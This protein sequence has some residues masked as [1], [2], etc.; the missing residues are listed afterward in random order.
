ML[1]SHR[2][3]VLLLSFTISLTACVPAMLTG[4]KEVAFVSA[5][6]Q[7]SLGDTVNDSTI[8]AEINH[9]FLQED[10]HDLL[11]N[12]DVTVRMGRVLLTGQVDSHDTARKATKLAWK[13][14]NVMEVITELDV[15]DEGND[16]FTRAND[17]WIEKQLE[18][19]LTMAKDVNIFNY[20]IEVTNGV[21]YLLG[22]VMDEAEHQR[23]LKVASTTSGVKKVISHLRLPSQ[24]RE[25]PIKNG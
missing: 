24:Y 4:A 16:V 15:A 8:Y 10:V 19:R 18:I 20:S 2:S 22:L 13:A 3:V 21:V 6:K 11:M 1:T 17:E 5:D 25:A 23:V 9:Y 7:R 12:V 14:G